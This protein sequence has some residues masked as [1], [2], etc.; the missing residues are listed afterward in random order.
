MKEYVR[1]KYDVVPQDMLFSPPYSEDS[2]P[3]LSGTEGSTTGERK[4]SEV[5]PFPSMVQ[6]SSGYY[7]LT[8][9]SCL[10]Y[11]QTTLSE[12]PLKQIPIR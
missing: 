9:K 7:F 2:N 3:I 11:P 5:D 6:Y 1:G 8:S 10:W 12:Y 4:L